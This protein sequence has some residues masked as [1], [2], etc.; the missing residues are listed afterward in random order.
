MAKKLPK[1]REGSM[2]EMS[3]LISQA[4]AGRIRKVS[5][6]AVSDLIRR[7][8]IRSVEIGGHI[9][10][11]RSEV[12]G[13]EELRRGWPKGKSRKVEAGKKGSKKKGSKK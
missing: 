7:G 10:V 1:K 13:F 9:L 11:Y 2:G 3:D 6:A 4:E 12:E 8:R 5:R